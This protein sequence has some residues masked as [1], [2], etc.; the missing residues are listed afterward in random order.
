MANSDEPEWIQFF[1][2]KLGGPKQDRKEIMR[3]M[4]K[5]GRKKSITFIERYS[6]I[7]NM[8]NDICRDK[9]M[10]SFDWKWNVYWNNIM[11]KLNPTNS[12]TNN[13]NKRKNTK[14]SKDELEQLRLE[15]KNPKEMIAKV[16]IEFIFEVF[17]EHFDYKSHIN[18]N[19]Y[20]YDKINIYY[21]DKDENK[22]SEWVVHKTATL[23]SKDNEYYKELIKFAIYCVEDIDNP[24]QF[25][26]K[27]RHNTAGQTNIKYYII[28]RMCFVIL[29]DL[30]FAPKTLTKTSN[31]T[32]LF[33]RLTKLFEFISDIS[34]YYTI[35][36]D[37][38]G[39]SKEIIK[40]WESRYITCYFKFVNNNCIF[41]LNIFKFYE[42]HEYGT[43]LYE[44]AKHN[45]SHF[46]DV[47]LSDGYNCLIKSKFILRAQSPYNAAKAE[48]NVKVLATMEKYININNNSN[49]SNTS[50]QNRTQI[51][52]S[53]LKFRNQIEF[54][55][56][57]LLSLGF[58]K[59][60]ENEK[61]NFQTKFK[62]DLY[63]NPACFEGITSGKNH[64]LEKS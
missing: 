1:R 48:K 64:I 17:F 10:S 37:Y 12:K 15:L 45:N 61:T 52:T 32:V 58:T 28:N 39:Y 11:D 63:V 49:S 4:E 54:S 33:P 47:L 41:D 51:E 2:N 38:V 42:C 23:A 56:F 30:F 8:M 18:N 16:F 5:S 20:N 55:K 46:C 6:M 36:P 13:N 40:E 7:W 60:N 35:V 43:I 19:N 9:Y 31:S 3:E 25:K 26:F 57:F 62:D 21:D 22:D 53:Y 59:V 27:D 29:N 14:A 50:T 34:L 24:M 44:S